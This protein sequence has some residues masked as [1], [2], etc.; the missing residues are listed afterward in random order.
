M[1]IKAFPFSN[2]LTVLINLALV[3]VLYM[4][5]R[6]AFILENWST[7]S[8]G[9]DQLSMGELLAGSLRFDSS[10]ILYTNCLWIVLMLFPLHLKERP[11]W[12]QMC[13]WIFV[14]I[15]SFCLSINLVDTVYSQ[16][17][18]RRTTA[19]FFSEFSNEG[20]LGGIFFTELINHWYLL[21]LGLTLIAALWF[22]Y[23]KP[24]N[25]PLN[26][27]VSQ[28]LSHT[29]LKYYLATSL[30]LIVAIPF[31]I[32]AMRGGFTGS[33]RPITISNAN[34]YV[35]SPQQASIVLNTP[36]SIIRT[37]GKHPFKDPKYMPEEQLATIYT[38]LHIPSPADT[39]PMV[40]GQKNV[41]VIILESFSREYFGY[42]NQALRQS[43]PDFVSYTPF[44][45]SLLEHSLTFEHTFANGRKSIDAM[46]SS[47]SSVPFFI[48]PFI[49]TPSSLNDLSGLADCLGQ[50]GYHSAFFHGAPNSSMGFQ[51]FARSSGFK[52]Y[53][54]MSEYCDDPRTG[55]RDD[56]DGHWAIWDEDFLQFTAT[57]ITERLK[58]P[59]VVGFFSA[60]SH[61]PFN[62]PQRY[63][64]V[65]LGGPLP[66]HR[67]IQYSDN[68]LRHFFATASQQPW[69]KNTLFVFT[70]DHTS[71]HQYDESHTSVGVFSIPI[72]IYDPSGEL[73]TGMLPGV[74]QQIDIMPS[75]LR[76]L[77]YDQPFSAFGKNVFDPNETPWAVNFSNDI[78]Q[79]IEGD[80]TLLFDGEQPTGLYNYVLDPLQNNDL[81]KSE[82]QRVNAMLTRLKA[83]VQT[84][85]IR[86]TTNHLVIRPG[87]L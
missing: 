6:V 22:L 8:V 78:Y 75:V 82:P 3:Y 71:R 7:L 70:A 16:F 18:G 38:P 40:S 83:I 69:F 58:E 80:Y 46:P 63:E 14:V 48:E 76:I 12:H 45:D 56:F 35:H 21:L 31:S 1:K 60:T 15:N 81:L 29:K 55:G 42:Y 25:S 73:P 33:T 84:Y 4:V 19:T 62:V 86:M 30:G 10:A 79:Y 13:K 85:M 20:N 52:Q 23:V 11:W 39:I 67:T 9:W 37:I 87:D 27:S 54:G 41:M 49:L 77:G 57:A 44:L 50:K 17:T 43:H 64:D 34:Q 47:L 24:D 32:F 51:A 53:I 74:M 5:T 68:A 65:Y 36:F 26:H 61:H 59:F 2:V 72:A 28:S 66:I